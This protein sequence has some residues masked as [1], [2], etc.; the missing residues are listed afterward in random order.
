MRRDIRKNNEIKIFCAVLMA[1]L[2]MVAFTCCV[3]RSIE[4]SGSGD[5]GQVTLFTPPSDTGSVETTT[6]DP[7]VTS[8]PLITMP[9]DTSDIETT[10][11]QPEQTTEPTETTSPEDTVYD[12]FS[13]LY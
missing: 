12:N 2:F 3:N 10:T 6:A 9:P 4:P 5:H 8:E 1:M 11:G 13:G 7:Y